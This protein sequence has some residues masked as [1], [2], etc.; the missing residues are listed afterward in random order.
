MKPT[1]SRQDLPLLWCCL[2]MTSA[3]YGAKAA[4][5]ALQSPDVNAL[6]INAAPPLGYSLFASMLCLLFER[7]ILGILRFRDYQ[8]FFRTP[9]T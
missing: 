8:D 3:L 1:H 9:S 6:V 4:I 5:I 7:K 2:T